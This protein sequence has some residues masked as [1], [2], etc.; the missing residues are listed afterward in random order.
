MPLNIYIYAI[1]MAG[2][3]PGYYNFLRKN[4]SVKKNV[5]TTQ[6]YLSSLSYGLHIYAL[7]FVSFVLKHAVQSFLI[8]LLC[9]KSFH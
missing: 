5:E 6:V 8:F 2:G 7:I 3:W 4:K 1:T 9:Q